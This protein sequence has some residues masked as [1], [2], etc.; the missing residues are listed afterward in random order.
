MGAD[1]AGC[2]AYLES[3][4]DFVTV[5]HLYPYNNS[6]KDN[7]RQAIMN[8]NATVL[9][10]QSRNLLVIDLSNNQEV[11]VR[12]S[13]PNR[14]S[15]GDRVRIRYDGKMTRSIPPQITASSI[16]FIRQTPPPQPP[17]PPI[18]PSRPPQA[19][20]PSEIRAIVTQTC[21][22]FLMVRDMQSNR[23]MRVN[24]SNANQFRVGH[25]V[26]IWYDTIFMGNPP[27]IN[28]TAINQIIG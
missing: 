11:L 5:E 17:R 24:Y 26:I 7:W 18:Q 9:R 16:Q 2:I 25:R 12:Y 13:N 15:V 27:V 8:M 22:G 4:S 20:T 10:V 23:I 21:R 1:K 14:F 3:Q 28:A 19:S 6:K